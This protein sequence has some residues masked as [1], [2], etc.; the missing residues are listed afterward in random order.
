MGST[1]YLS[2]T[3]C[4]ATSSKSKQ[5]ITIDERNPNNPVI[6]RSWD[7]CSALRPIHQQGL[8]TA[9]HEN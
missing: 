7:I 2:Y 4:F 1:D 8:P 5:G 9:P 3:V 6:G